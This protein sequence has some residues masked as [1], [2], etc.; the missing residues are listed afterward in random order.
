MSRRQK[1][2]YK[3]I[4]V[5]KYNETGDFVADTAFSLKLIVV[6]TQIGNNFGYLRRLHFS[7]W[8]Y[9]CYVIY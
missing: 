3:I 5:R 7:A 1:I 2:I 8:Y 4:S 9:F 6:F